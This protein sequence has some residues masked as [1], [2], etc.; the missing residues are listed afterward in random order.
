MTMALELIAPAKLNLTLEVTGRR[1]DGYHELVTVMQTID[2][3]DRVRLDEAPSLE[4]DISGEKQ[5]GV[6]VEGPRNLAFKAAQALAAAVGL[7]N[8]GA[9]IQLEKNIPAG[10]G[11][12]GGSTDAAAV[13]RGLCTLWRLDLDAAVLNDIAASIGSDVPFFL[14][15]GAALVTGRGECVEPLPDGAPLTLTLFGSEVEIDDKTRRMYSTLVPADYTDGRHGHVVAES[16]RRGLPIAETDYYNA[17]DRHIGTVA[18][19]LARAMALC[20][21]AGLAVIASGSGPSFFAP[22]SIDTIPTTLLR[23][24]EHD[25]GVHATACRSLTRAQSTAMREV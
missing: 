7:A 2:L 4:I 3:A 14:H 18:E 11:L 5:L 23:E 13:L 9:S 24:L 6:P 10:M 22:T 19:P 15:G 20:R 21:E 1:P 12:G 17:F 25:W 8:A 16:I